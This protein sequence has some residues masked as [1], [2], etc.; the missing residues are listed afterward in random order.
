MDGLYEISLK[1]PRGAINGNLKLVT[2]DNKLS[3][4]IEVMG[5]RYELCN[6]SIDGNKFMINGNFKVALRNI[7]YNVQGEVLNDKIN[8][9]ARTNMGSFNLQGKKIS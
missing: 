7:R 6:G 4:Y 8:I 5:K 9:Y 2:N 3:G 1:T